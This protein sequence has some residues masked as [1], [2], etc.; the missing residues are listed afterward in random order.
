M[1]RWIS[2]GLILITA[3]A[4]ALRGP[5]LS[6]RPMHNDEAVNA[7]KLHA[8]WQK[9]DYRYDPDE[10][11]GPTLYYSAL[12]F[13]W[14]SGAQ[15]FQH[16]SE[17]TLREVTVFF[18]LALILLL[19][20]LLDGLGSSACL[21]AAAL[22]A[23]SPAFVFYSRYFIH[24]ILLVCFTLLVIGAG[25]RYTR[26]PSAG[27]AAVG[28]A[29]VGLMYATKETFIIALAAMLGALALTAAGA[30]ARETS[31]QPWR[32][33]WNWKHALVAAGAGAGV[34]LLLFTSFFTNASGPVDSFRTYLPWLK[35]AEGQSPHI[36]PWSFY[37]ERLLYF[38]EGKGPVWSEGLVGALALIGSVAAFARPDSLKA[39][40]SLSRFL[41]FYTVLLTAAYSLIAYKTPWCLLGFWHGMILLAGLGVTFLFRICNRFI[42]RLV[43]GAVLLAGA[44]QLTWQ[45]WRA[46][47]VYAADRHNP[48]VYAQTSPDLL[49]LVAKVDDLAK[50][51]PE[52]D[53][54]LV[55]VI[56][57]E[58]D[59][60]PLPWYL[61]KFKQVGWWDRLP[62]NPYAPIMIVGAKLHAALDDKSDKA[63]LMVG[64][65]ELR[66]KT[67]LELYV[68]FDLWQKYLQNRPRESDG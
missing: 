24:E 16:L 36:H 47:Y 29:G 64:Y 35:R 31:P 34:S 32:S 28:G 12:P 45:S 14:L 62:A 66:P 63:W 43:L 18:G 20:L 50:A 5:D 1:N 8:L 55:K 49:R 15:D 65:Y 53:G 2:L 9:G 54:T 67:F 26:T 10:H 11:H 40:C 56:A 42:P 6:L 52:G 46:S 19:W 58:S 37:L 38:R 23:I 59:Y 22:T 44:A 60:W 68:Q 39:N 13:V 30:R 51:A 4:W 21:V 57:P 41:V 17:T 48:Y 61:R 25:W 3:G 33:C 27:W 7:I